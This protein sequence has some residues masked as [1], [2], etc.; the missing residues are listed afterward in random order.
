MINFF[1]KFEKSYFLDIEKTIK[2]C[3]YTC[4]TGN[5]FQIRATVK[6]TQKFFFP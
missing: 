6:D 2:K 4:T 3:S 1:K 5:N